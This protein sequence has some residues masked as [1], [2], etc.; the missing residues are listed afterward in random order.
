MRQIEKRV[1]P[2]DIGAFAVGLAVTVGSSLLTSVVS[3]IPFPFN[4][5]ISFGLGGTA[6]YGTRKILDPRT[7]SEITEQ[8]TD[9]EFHA[10]LREVS[11][12]AS[13]TMAAGKS[14]HVDKEL[15]GRLVAMA[16]MIRMIHERYQERKR[17]FAGVSS[18]L[19]VL[20][21]VDGILAHYVKV[22]NG[23]LF[24]DQGQ[25]ETVIFE[26]EEHVIP[27]VEEALQN[28]GRKL[29]AGEGVATG[30][31]RATLE[32]LLRLAGLIESIK[33][34]SGISNKGEV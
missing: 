29:D 26:T 32:S 17:D 11:E 19:L 14:K 7:A 6:L 5:L 3:P 25:R 2:Q 23:E 30:I 33:D 28:L 31:S 8:Q 21:Q 4:V 18:T 27:M 9:A 16:E 12:I 10:M 24:L 15:S 34:A 1:T 13:R 20:Q 22:K